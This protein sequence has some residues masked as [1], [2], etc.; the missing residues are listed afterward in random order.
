MPRASTRMQIK[1]RS[2]QLPEG[3]PSGTTFRLIIGL[4]E[5]AIII[6]KNADWQR[7]VEDNVQYLAGKFQ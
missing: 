4:E 1:D 7:F 5:L 3:L 6:I 2:S